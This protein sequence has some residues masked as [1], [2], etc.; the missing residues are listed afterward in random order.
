VPIDRAVAIA[1][2]ITR[3]VDAAAPV[4]VKPKEADD[5]VQRVDDALRAADQ[6]R[7]DE[8]EKKLREAAEKIDE[9]VA[10]DET[11]AA[12]QS[13]LVDLA[14]EL[15]VDDDVVTE[16]FRGDDDDDDDD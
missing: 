1:D 14:D 15:G 3:V 4:E 13:L 12:L 5:I 11:R 10:G 16:P 6:D 2:E 8:V 9:H 7:T